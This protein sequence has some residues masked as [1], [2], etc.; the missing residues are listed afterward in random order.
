MKNGKIILIHFT[1]A[2]ERGGKERVI[3]DLTKNLDPSM[4]DSYVLCLNHAGSLAA[5][6]SGRVLHLRQSN[7]RL[8]FLKRILTLAGAVRCLHAS[9]AHFVI[10]HN[11][12]ANFYAA[13]SSV[14]C[15]KKNF[16]AV[17]HSYDSRA[18]NT[19]LRKV[20][21]RWILGR[22][23]ATACVSQNV[24]DSF[25]SIHPRINRGTQHVIRNGVDYSRFTIGPCSGKIRRQFNLNLSQPVIG[26]IGHLTSAKALDI[27]INSMK[28][29]TES[30][31]EAA[32][33][34]VGEGPQKQSLMDLAAA[35][36]LE[37]QIFFLGERKDV[38]KIL[39]S[40]NIFVLSSIR[41]GLPVSLLEAMACGKPVVV[42][43]VG[44]IPEVVEDGETGFIVNP[45]DSAALAG[46]IIKLLREPGAASEMGARARQRILNHFSVERMSRSFEMLLQGLSKGRQCPDSYSSTTNIES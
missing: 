12:S 38:Q 19:L 30:I 4:F 3:V 36:G 23:R 6:I 45:S 31:P 11:F 44:G 20:L 29:V 43:N 33:L 35:N 13:L 40:I 21:T 18:E 15:R 32:L 9:D 22:A 8:R 16:V 25:L 39:N 34:I 17:L 26:T 37:K 10:G 1:D 14:I 24:A 41:E 2:L 28:I 27:L 46:R 42:T 5:E 7:T